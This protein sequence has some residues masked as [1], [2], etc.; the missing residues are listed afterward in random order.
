MSGF[1]SESFAQRW[2]TLSLVDQLGNIGSEIERISSWKKKNNST[3]ATQALYRTLELLD[4]SIGDSRWQGGTL[5][6]LARVREIVCDFFVGDN[7]YK[8]SSEF[9]SRYFHAFA[10]A[11]RR[12]S[13]S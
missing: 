3:H 7:V 1:S 4:L 6:E 9:L 8:T 11:A 12:K 13:G 10:V 5:K 2:H